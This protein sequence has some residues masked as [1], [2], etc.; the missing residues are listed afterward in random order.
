MKNIIT[1]EIEKSKIEE[2]LNITETKF[3][4]LEHMRIGKNHENENRN[5]PIKIILDSELERNQ[6]LANANKLKNNNI[7]NIRISREFS[8][9]QLETI[10]KLIEEITKNPSQNKQSVRFIDN[11]FKIIQIRNYTNK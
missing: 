9:E 10:T 2:I 3:T 11:N 5:R 4:I 7:N 6:I 8:K 1:K